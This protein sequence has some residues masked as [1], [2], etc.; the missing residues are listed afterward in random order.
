MNKFKS[1][2]VLVLGVLLSLA[3]CGGG[4]SSGGG[5]GASTKYQKVDKAFKGVEASLSNISHGRR[6]LVN[7]KKSIDIDEDMSVLQPFFVGAQEDERI[8]DQIDFDTPPLIQFKYLKAIYENIGASYSFGT[9]Y[10]HNIVGAVY[11]DIETGKKDETQS[12][13]NKLQYN[14]NFSVCVNIDDNDLISANVGM[15]VVL[16]KGS[17]SYKYTKYAY[18][19][20]DYDFSKNDNNFK[21]A[22]YDYGEET[23]LSYLHS[24]ISYEYNYA[25]VGNSNLVEWRKCRYE[26]SRKVYKDASHPTLDSYINEGVDIYRDNQRWYKNN[27]LKRVDGSTQQSLEIA[28]LLFKDFGL[29]NTDL[30]PEGYF[31]APFT[32]S[33]VIESIYR[34][35]SSVYGDELMYHLLSGGDSGEEE[36]DKHEWPYHDIKNITG[37]D[38]IVFSNK[39]DITYESNRSDV[40]GQYKSVNIKITGASNADYDAFVQLLIDNGL[41]SNESQQ[42]VEVYTMMLIDNS[43]I[44][45]S[46]SRS[47]N[48]IVIGCTVPA[49]PSK[50]NKIIVDNGIDFDLPYSSLNANF[51]P[52]EKDVLEVLSHVLKE[53]DPGKYF[54]G[55]TALDINRGYILGYNDKIIEDVEGAKTLEEAI[56]S[57]K[58][59]YMSYYAEAWT[60]T[61]NNNV[62]VHKI[63]DRAEDAII[64]DDSSLSSYQLT[65]YI[66][67]FTDSAL[68][69]YLNGELSTIPVPVY[70]HDISE[71]YLWGTYEANEGDNIHSYLDD[72]KKFYLDF[73]MSIPL[74]D[75]NCFVY[76]GMEL[77]F[78]N[79]PQEYE[80]ITVLGG[81]DYELPYSNYGAEYISDKNTAIDAVCNLLGD[82]SIADY[83]S[84]NIDVR[85][86]TCA[87]YFIEIGPEIAQQ[88]GYES[89]SEGASY[90]YDQYLNCYSSWT[91]G[92]RASVDYYF[93]DTDGVDELVIFDARTIEVGQISFLHVRLK[94]SVMQDYENNVEP[95]YN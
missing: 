76:K 90:L 8:E 52:G 42:G 88:L 49:E 61:S 67:R 46:I 53:N 63:D 56:L 66:L 54:S 95:N 82:L 80:P 37:F 65:F 87:R 34:Q 36:E 26:A 83:I 16:N 64:F 24:G 62:F 32:D 60:F 13:A 18:M 47:T 84:N 59:T 20:L 75:E 41:V 39:E 19:L 4:G 89:I 21:L 81:V 70:C 12:E 28:K 73:D 92:T 91:K 2:C 69:K 77:H 94:P 45:I 17:D 7:P 74:T 78:S 6:N 35:A 1:T 10:A 3:S 33:S 43:M 27:V 38:W 71:V 50:Y 51:N 93:L 40:E 22:L 72:D 55:K 58:K 79:V 48:Q 44:F 68:S 11:I 15:N 31:S 85:S 14:F 23:E 86:K 9:K 57:I 25:E 29:N 30:N 5:G